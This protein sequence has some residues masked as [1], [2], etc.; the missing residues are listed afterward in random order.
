MIRSHLFAEEREPWVAICSG[1]VAEDLVV[2]TIFLDHIKYVPDR[3]SSVGLCRKVV[4]TR[5]N[6]G[7]HGCGLLWRPVRNCLL[8]MLRQ[9]LRG[10]EG[11]ASAKQS[12]NPGIA[13]RIRLRCI[14]T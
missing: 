14:R 3:I 6:P 10:Y 4:L 12:A 1:H 8:R 9:P 5:G 11:N 2:G 7:S 13:S